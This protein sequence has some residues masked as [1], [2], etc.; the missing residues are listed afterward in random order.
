MFLQP[1]SL[2]K[3][4]YPPH[5]KHL[6]DRKPIS[7]LAEY[8]IELPIASYFASADSSKNL[9]AHVPL[10]ALFF[11]LGELFPKPIFPLFYFFFVES[12]ILLIR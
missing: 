11:L 6:R 8:V 3:S 1:G 12:C 10:I 9:E 7:N 2:G 5:V 4:A